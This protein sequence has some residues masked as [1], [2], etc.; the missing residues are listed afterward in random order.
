M[1][2]KKF[3]AIIALAVLILPTSAHATTTNLI[4]NG[5]FSSG[6][7]NWTTGGSVTFPNVAICGGSSSPRV[8]LDPGES[9]EQTFD[10]GVFSLYELIAT[11][12]LINDTDNYYDQLAISVKNNDTGVM[13]VFYLRGS[14]WTNCPWNAQYHTM[15]ND[16][17]NANVTVRFYV[18]SLSTS[19]W[20]IDNV[21]FWAT[22]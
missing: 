1:N 9:I 4:T 21:G 16:Y 14:L 20:Y 3:I 17:D 6:S 15:S 13:E 2:F 12:H 5:N 19:G 11:Y 18:S 10:V 7:A 22:T 8:Q